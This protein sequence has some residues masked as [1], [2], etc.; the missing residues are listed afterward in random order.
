MSKLSCVCTIYEL[1]QADLSATVACAQTRTGP[2]TNCNNQWPGAQS[3]SSL[4]SIWNPWKS[5]KHEFVC[6]MSLR[7]LTNF[8]T[9]TMLG[10]YGQNV[11]C[12]YK[13]GFDPLAGDGD[14]DDYMLHLTNRHSMQT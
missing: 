6:D 1:M 11:L 12:T 4:L 7:S 5:T 8:D 9:I 14:M 10:R 13:R 3:G 2:C